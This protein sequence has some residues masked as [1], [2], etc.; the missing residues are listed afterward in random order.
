M[1][2]IALHAVQGGSGRTTL[3]RALA[4]AFAAQGRGVL[5]LDAT[6]P[7][8]IPD[9]G[10]WFDAQDDDPLSRRVR[11]ARARTE[12]DVARALRLGAT[13]GLD[14]AVID[15][16]R[17]PVRSGDRLLAG[18]LLAA[19]LILI[20]VR[21]PHEVERARDEI[22][23]MGEDLPAAAVA[24][25]PPDEPARRALHTAWRAGDGAPGGLLHA[26][27][28]RHPALDH[29]AD[30]R[31]W[32]HAAH[33]ALQAREGGRRPDL[34]GTGPD[35]TDLFARQPYDPVRLADHAAAVRGANLLAAEV[36][37]RLEGLRPVPLHPPDTT[38]PLAL[39]GV[40]PTPRPRA[41][42]GP[43]GPKPPAPPDA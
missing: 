20:P 17:L 43:G 16:P 12:P 34:A 25:D 42:P 13:A 26:S 15:G 39:L 5:V 11:L 33:A 37:L 23:E 7:G 35:L 31:R 29:E 4:S 38:P 30:L 32:P 21:R 36:L 2:V 40:T 28:P 8:H 22:A 6:A 18:A 14:L 3:A 9:W 1:Q 27:L 24:V 41:K 19:H 10:R